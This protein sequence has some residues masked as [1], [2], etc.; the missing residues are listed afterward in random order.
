VSRVNRDEGLDAPGPDDR[1]EARTR[2]AK[3]RAR[4]KA[5]LARGVLEYAICVGVL[6]LFFPPLA[7]IVG[8]FWGLGLASDLVKKGVGPELQRRWVRREVARELGSSVPVERREIEDRNS[9]RLEELSAQ[10]AH[11]IRNPITAAK[12]LVQQMGEDPASGEN[13][14]YARVALQELDRVEKSI[15]HLLR[16]A[17]EEDL[18]VAEVYMA[19]V[20]ESAVEAFADRIESQGATVQT[21]IDGPAQIRGDAEQLRRMLLNLIGNALDALAEAGTPDPRLEIE[22]GEN[23]AGSEVWVRVRDNGPGIDAD[24]RQ[25][26]WSPFYTSRESGTG[27]GL[28]VS[29]KV[30]DAHGGS[31]EL[32]SQ[33]GRGTDFLL[34][35]PKRGLEERASSSP[36]LEGAR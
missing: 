4:T 28:A 1:I 5:K 30:I 15:A 19:D 2:Y 17:R 33:P 22:V 34:T 20:V 31:V 14:G 6:A 7:W 13:V 24:R 35:F 25:R 3:S 32:S 26:I 36:S 11:E 10:V 18:R 21:R 29:K 27:L 23:L 8:L 16:F 12:S 9:R